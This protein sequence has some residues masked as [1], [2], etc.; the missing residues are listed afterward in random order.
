VR[1]GN[2]DGAGSNRHDRSHRPDRTTLTYLTFGPYPMSVRASLSGS[3]FTVTRSF[4][5]TIVGR[6]AVV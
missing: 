3:F 6:V 1:R 4:S 2:D 5:N